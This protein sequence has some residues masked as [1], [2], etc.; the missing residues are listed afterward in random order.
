MY[1]A[2]TKWE[3]TLKYEIEFLEF[4]CAVNRN[5]LAWHCWYLKIPLIVC[6]AIYDNSKDGGKEVLTK[7]HC[8]F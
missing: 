5:I 6:I 8:V 2:Q 4:N 1:C 7:M 3:V